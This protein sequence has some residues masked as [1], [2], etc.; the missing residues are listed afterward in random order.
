M[1]TLLFP[2]VEIIYFFVLNILF[3]RVTI[4]YCAVGGMANIC[5]QSR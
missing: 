5:K 3:R 4:F 1:K 2:I